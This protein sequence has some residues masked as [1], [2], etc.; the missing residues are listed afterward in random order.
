MQ[1]VR[2]S[3]S[4]LEPYAKGAYVNLSDE[5]DESALRT[6]YGAAKYAR[7]QSIKAKYDPENLFRLNQNIKPAVA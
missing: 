6:T 3:W 2:D 7:L 1:W 4:A 5:L